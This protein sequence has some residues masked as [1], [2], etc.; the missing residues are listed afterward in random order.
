MRR[1][2][3]GGEFRACMPNPRQAG[4]FLAACLVAFSCAALGDKVYFSEQ[5]SQTIF[6][7]N[8]DGSEVQPIVAGVGTVDSIAI[9]PTNGYL[10][11]T[12]LGGDDSPSFG[13]RAIRRSSLDGTNVTTIVGSAFSGSFSALAIDLVRQRLYWTDS[14]DNNIRSANVDGSDQQ[15]LISNVQNPDGIAVDPESQKMY[16]TETTFSQRVRR[17]NLDGSDPQ[18]LITTGLSQPLGIALDIENG[19]MYFTNSLSETIERANFD[20]SSREEL[21]STS[22]LSFPAYIALDPEKQKMY[23]TE[24]AFTS[25]LVRR[26]SIDGSD[27][28]DL[29]A[30]IN[31]VA[32]A[33]LDTQAAIVSIDIKPG[34][35]KNC[36]KFDGRGTISVAVLGDADVDTINIDISTLDFDGLPVAAKRSG[37]T[38]CDRADVNSDGFWDLVCSFIESTETWTGGPTE[39]TLTGAFFGG[40]EFEGTDTICLK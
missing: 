28:Q 20:G 13:E 7:M 21:L 36:V 29:F 11:W 14:L 24:A 30:G 18:D 38:S 5:T 9:D 10:Y 2:A 34:N 26:A 16:W 22:V 19:K 31:P 32:I 39:A 40:A 15:V 4:R 35:D 33:Y 27:V 8:V 25:G 1:T 23:W 12:Q 17:A 3:I 37:Q 6:R